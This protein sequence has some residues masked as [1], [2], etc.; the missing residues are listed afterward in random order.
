MVKNKVK[1]KKIYDWW[2]SGGSDP[3][4]ITAVLGTIGDPISAGST[5][6]KTTTWFMSQSLPIASVLKEFKCYATATGTIKVKIAEPI[7]GGGFNIIYNQTFTCSAIGVNTFVIPDVDV[8]AN[9]LVGFHTPSSG[10]ATVSFRSDGAP[11]FYPGYLAGTGDLSGNGVALNSISYSSELQAQYTVEYTRSSPGQYIIDENFAANVLPAYA[12]NNGTNPWSFAGGVATSTGTGLASFLD[13]YPELEIDRITVSRNFP[14]TAAGQI[15]A[16]YR[17]PFFGDASATDGTIGAADLDN[18]RLILYQTWT[19]GTNF[20]LP[21]ISSTLVLS[22]LTLQTG[23]EYRLELKKTAKVTTLKIIRV[24]DGVS[25]TLTSNND[26]TVL[27][28]LC[29]GRMGIA[30]FG[31]V[32]PNYSVQMYADV[33]NPKS[34]WVGDSITEESG[35]T[36]GNGYAQ[37][38]LNSL[39]G[40]GWFSGDGGTISLNAL[41]RIRHILRISMPRYVA[42]YI[43]ANNSATAGDTTRF[44]GDVETAHDTVINYGADIIHYTITPNSDSTRNGRNITMNGQ[45]LAKPWEFVRGDL[46]LSLNNDGSTWDSS[47][48]PD[49]VHPNTVGHQ[50]LKN[51]TQ[52]D[53]PQ[54]VTP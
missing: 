45:L 1:I 10:G 13:W 12:I 40:N 14:F 2:A 29:Y 43:G 33:V 48:I 3:S 15:R 44:I 18:N 16:L 41:K 38:C 52:S 28:G 24:S 47:L 31:S 6:N 46:E 9:S 17:K 54:V 11:S 42:L 32:G 5:V 53:Q 7:K 49:G 39:S 21:S 26:P 51:R 22:N 37:L 36:S 8:P 35:T 34:V 50:R 23:V 19:G 4:P 20:T 25:E 27:S 30:D